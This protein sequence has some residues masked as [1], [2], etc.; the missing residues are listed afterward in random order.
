ML[1]RDLHHVLSHS[2]SKTYIA[3]WKRFSTFARSQLHRRP[4][5]ASG[6]MVALYAT[7]LHSEGLKSTSIRSHLSAIAF[8][9][10]IKGFNNPAQ[11]FLLDK[12]L[13]SYR[14]L[15][16]PSSVRKPISFQLL[17]LLI[18]T[19]NTSPDF[20]RYE[21]KLYQAVF[22]LMYYGALRSSEVCFSRL[23]SHTLQIDHITLCHRKGA[24]ALKVKLPSFK[25]SRGDTTPLLLQPDA[26]QACP[27][28]LYRK[29]L[30]L[31]G[32]HKGQAFCFENKSPLS[33]R[34]L[35]STLRSLISQAGRNPQHYNTHSFRIGRAT[36]MAQQGHS[37]SQ[38]AL[39]G[40]WRSD[41][42]KKYIKPSVIHCR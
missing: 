34:F 35:A 17:T 23:H 21:K 32:N 6:H 37:N 20:T 9:H 4:R 18:T 41:A 13:S 14:K 24:P 22:S 36:D 19:L 40:R 31:R 1:K 12:L 16:G 38:I 30:S 42:F 8:Y 7:R 26:I 29:F 5:P 27:V 25:H 33:R 10:K 11:T 2:A 3:C 15:E 28:V 39:A